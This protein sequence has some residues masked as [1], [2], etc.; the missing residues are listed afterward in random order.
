MEDAES[1]L[2]QRALAGDRAAFD[3]LARRHRGGLLRSIRL[4]ISDADEA[5]NLLQDTLARALAGLER[6]RPELRFG[7]W[8]HGI[9]LNVCR[10]QLRDRNR[11]ARTMEPERL[12]QVSAPGRGHG[13]L[14]GIVHRELGDCLSQAIGLLP[15]PLREAFVLHFVDGLG[16]AEMSQFTG[17]AAGTLRVRSHRARVLLRA[18]L[19]PVVDTWLLQAR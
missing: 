8:L 17:I 6:F 4:L 14:S 16:Y 5:E 2:A 10:T 12:G 1:A 13:V 15:M 11:H 3:E 9:A 18:N 7:A 19:G